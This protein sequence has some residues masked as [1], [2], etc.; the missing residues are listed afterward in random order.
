VVLVCG[1]IRTT[2]GLPKE[3]SAIH[4]DQHGR[5]IGLS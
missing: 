2:A 1:E 3:A 5:I 4:V